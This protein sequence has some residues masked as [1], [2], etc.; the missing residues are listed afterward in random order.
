MSKIRFFTGEHYHVYNRGIEKRDIFYDYADY[1][2]FLNNLEKFNNNDELA[3]NPEPKERTALVGVVA[4]CF[5]PNHFHLILQ[6]KIDGGIPKYIQRLATGYTMYFN[7]RYE[8]SGVLFQ[9]GFKAKHIENDQYLFYLS[10][11]VHLNPVDI[12]KSQEKGSVL[13]DLFNYEWSSL[14]FYLEPDRLSIVSL[15]K[16]TILKYIG[17][18]E[19]YRRDISNHTEC[20]LKVLQFIKID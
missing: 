20:D 5:M 8:R 18:V 19:D 6:Q 17:S 10:R 13:K 12:L 3:F 15:Q 7:K 2:R 4:Y 1:S 11:Y 14:P 9:G 16:E